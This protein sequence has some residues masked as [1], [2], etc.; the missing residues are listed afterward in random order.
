M[1][2]RVLVK[3]E[4]N[5]LRPGLILDVIC[6]IYRPAQGLLLSTTQSNTP[7]CLTMVFSPS[8]QNKTPISTNVCISPCSVFLTKLFR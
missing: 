8:I 7:G 6:D 5:S 3:A 1:E 4:L 2:Y